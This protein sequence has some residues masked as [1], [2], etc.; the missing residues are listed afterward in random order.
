MRDPKSSDNILPKKSLGIHIPN[1]GQWFNF[2][3]FGEVICANQQIPLIHYCLRKMTYNV[4]TPLSKRPRTGQWIKNSFRLMN[5]WSKS[6]ALITL[7]H[8]LLSFHLHIWPPITLSE[9]PVRQ[10]ST[11][12]MAFTNSFI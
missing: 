3:L 12:C 11:P 5:V 7:L 9:G 1:I 2:N 10:R 8:I 6:L 4:Q